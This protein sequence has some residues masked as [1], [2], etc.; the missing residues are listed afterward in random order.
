MDRP[1]QAGDIDSRQPRIA[2]L[3]FTSRADVHVEANQL[4]SRCPQRANRVTKPSSHRSDELLHRHGD[5]FIRCFPLCTLHFGRALVRSCRDGGSPRENSRISCEYD[6]PLGAFLLL[7]VARS[8]G[9][10]NIFTKKDSAT[11]VS[12]SNQFAYAV[13]QERSYLVCSAN[14]FPDSRN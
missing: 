5:R 11:T 1:H 4:R 13:A 12:A 6:T 8:S 10:S 14:G 7:T 2:H 3:L 9:L